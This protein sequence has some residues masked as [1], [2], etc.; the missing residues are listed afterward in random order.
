MLTQNNNRHFFNKGFTLAEALITLAVI[1]IVAALT[2]PNLVQSY[3]KRVVETK[4]VKFY[5]EIN[6]AVQLAEIEYGDKKLW[7][8]DLAGA[9]LDED[10]NVIE[11]SSKSEKW[12]K[13][14]LGKYIKSLRYDYSWNGSMLVHFPN[15]STLRQ[16]NPGTTRD[17]TFYPDNF[18]KCD[19]KKEFNDPRTDC[20]GICCF[21][22]QFY[23]ND[24]RQAWKYH[25]NKGFEPWKYNWNGTKE[26][27]YNV[28]AAKENTTP[29]SGSTYRQ[30]CTALIES[31]GWK[32]P[33]DYPWK[34]D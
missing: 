17:W 27:L 7:F 30:Y 8:E 10:G 31:N 2:I 18:E 22:F 5:A 12:F 14:Y 25:Y 1:G 16:V 6:Q 29:G 13:K 24:N 19:R 34:V 21:A 20:M 3:K 26:Q 4:L 15:G 11:G 9:D 32:I 33:K 28:C 23:P